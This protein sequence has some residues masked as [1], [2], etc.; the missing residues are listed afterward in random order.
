MPVLLMYMVL[1]PKRDPKRYKDVTWLFGE[2]KRVK[3][4]YSCGSTKKRL[5]PEFLLKATESCSSAA[6]ADAKGRLSSMFQA[7]IGAIPT[8]GTNLEPIA[9]DFAS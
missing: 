1:R 9:S 7:T 8:E 5:R 3:Q 2:D 4:G 6:N